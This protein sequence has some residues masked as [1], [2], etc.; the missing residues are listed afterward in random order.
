MNRAKDISHYVDSIQ[1]PEQRSEGDCV[2]RL[3]VNE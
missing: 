2:L 1:D 3:F